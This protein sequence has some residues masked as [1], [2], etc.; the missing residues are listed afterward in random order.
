MAVDPVL[1]PPPPPGPPT[2]DVSASAK[3]KRKK[4]NAKA[5]STQDVTLEAGGKLKVPIQ[6]GKKNRAPAAAKT[7]TFK[8]RD[9]SVELVA[10]VQKKVPF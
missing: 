7:K 8:V 3:Q 9:R 5:T 4:L 2:L 6:D 1:S 10:G